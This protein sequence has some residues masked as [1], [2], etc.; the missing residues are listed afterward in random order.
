MYMRICETLNAVGKLIP[1]NEDIYDHIKDNNKDY[2]SSI[3][4]YNEEQKNQFYE[5]IEVTSKNGNTYSRKRGIGGITDVITKK[6]VFDFDSEDNIPLAQTDTIKTVKRLQKHGI[7]IEDM[8]I[9]FSGCKGFSIEMN[10]DTEMTPEKVKT[11]AKY[12]A[13]DLKTFDTKVYNAARIF[14]LP[15]TKH[16]KTGLYKTPIQYH[17]LTDLNVDQIA[18]IASEYYIPEINK[19]IAKLPKTLKNIKPEDNSPVDSPKIDSKL[20]NAKLDLNLTNRPK[21]LSYWKYALLNGYFPPKSRS[22]ALMILASTFKSQGMPL[23]VTK[24]MLKGAIELQIARF[25]DKEY[26]E[27]ELKRNVLDQVYSELWEGGTYAEDNFPDDIKSYLLGL[28]IPRQE[29]SNTEDSFKNSNDVFTSFK[30]FAENIDQ[31]TIKTGIVPLDNEKSLRLTTSMLVGLLGAP[32]SGKSS[33]AFEVMKNASKSNQKV[34]F[35]SMDM[36]SPLVLQRLAQKVT[37]FDSDD[38]FEIFKNKDEK[39]SSK[40]ADKINEQYKNVHFCF[41]TALTVE[42]IK[43][44]IERE[45][46]RSGE[47]IKIAVIDY[48]ECINA[49]ISDPNAKISMISQQLKDLATDLDICVLLLL[50]PPKRVGD[51]SKEITTYTAIK[52]AATVAQACSIVISLWRDGFNPKDTENDNY[53]SFAVI[54]NRMGKLSQ[55]DCSWNGLTGKIG[56]LEDIE[57]QE[58]RNLRKNKKDEESS[59]DDF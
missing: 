28:G 18:E 3:Y 1:E 37:G 36:G 12:I 20:L 30:K 26:N 10:T 32:S 24:G 11:I 59:Y 58:L 55:I 35:F 56:T 8:T 52:G 39:Q 49:S 34:A 27:S 14:R 2:Y 13:G 47:K 25:N 31:N 44:N 4:L 51:P 16:N 45:Q 29:E 57:R 33:V 46:E 6:L 41:K 7:N 9:T 23:E 43:R 53:L 22:H 54:K 42:D 48:L 19:N 17:E 5:D 38:L 21:G 15:H 50:Q 40:I